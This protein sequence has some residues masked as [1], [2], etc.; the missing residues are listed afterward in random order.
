MAAAV[1]FSEQPWI[2]GLP[3]PFYN[4]SHHKWQKF[5]RE[6]FDE[7]INPYVLDWERDG[8][9][10]L[11]VYGIANLSDPRSRLI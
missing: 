1:P 5:C 6:Y 4:E 2:T 11:D 3:S 7:H 8:E 9:V 10:P